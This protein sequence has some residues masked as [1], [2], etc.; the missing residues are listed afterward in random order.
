MSIFSPGR[1]ERDSPGGTH[2]LEDTVARISA[3]AD[4]RD[5]HP[6]FPEDSFQHLAAAG[7]LALPVSDPIGEHGR[8]AT[9]AEEWR[10]L[11]AVARADGSVGRI[12]D[13]HFNGVERI[14]L[15][16]P[17]PLRSA[18]LEAIAAGEL[19]PGV[20]GADPI[21]G[22]GEPARLV[23]DD[24]GAKLVGVKTFCSGSTGL[25]RALVLVRGPAQGPPLLAYVD[26]FEKR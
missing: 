9:F 13:G 3:G 8:R 22:E 10:V 12:L 5:A 25:D 7:A 17:E 18:E 26:L 14:S 1:E 6:S 16:A 23:E 20:W 11:R 2:D 24:D 4:E 19:L 21:P 15:L